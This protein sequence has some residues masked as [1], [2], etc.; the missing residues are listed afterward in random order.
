MIKLPWTSETSPHFVLEIN[1]QCNI[2]CKG[3]YKVR[4][5]ADRSLEAITKDLH[6][7][8]SRSRIHTV[9][10]GGAEPTLHPE[11]CD[12]VR[13]LHDRG[14][15]T[16]LFTNGLLL[17]DELLVSLKRAGLDIV[18]LHVDEGQDRPDLSRNPSLQE[19]NFLR[20]RLAARIATH[21]ID[22]GLSVTIHGEGIDRIADL[23]RFVLESEH[24]NFLFATHYVDLHQM[25]SASHTWKHAAAE[26]SW[27]H[28]ARASFPSERTTNLDTTRILRE[29]FGLEPFAYLPSAS[30]A[31]PAEGT[32][33]WLT[34]YVP[35]IAG[36]E[37]HEFLRMESGAMDSFLISITSLLAR[38]FLFYIKPIPAVILAHVLLNAISEVKVPAAMRFLTSRR[39]PGGR[40]GAKRLV[41][42]NGPTLT[43]D[44]QIV[45]TEFCP[46]STVKNGKFIPVC[47]SDIEGQR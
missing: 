9:S 5:E 14:L 7:A 45:C 42:D 39:R 36:Q 22:V 24:I 43:A 46:N 26:E 11:L 44:G 40:L 32:P 4:S 30:H 19:T 12:I 27:H 1:Q 15:K 23:V 16:A 18:M 35:V 34:F 20:Q 6:T 33:S 47:M 21:R 41:F 17:D 37:K 13:L 3:C 10:I 25:V 8:M 31:N 38:R 29:S 2:S 28:Q